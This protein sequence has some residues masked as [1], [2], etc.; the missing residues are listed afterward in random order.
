MTIVKVHNNSVSQSDAVHMHLLHVVFISYTQ[1]NATI[2][3]AETNN[4]K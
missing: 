4:N 1:I 3:K 2:Y